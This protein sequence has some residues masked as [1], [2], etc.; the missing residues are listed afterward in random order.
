MIHWR[1]ECPWQWPTYD[2]IF[3]KYGAYHAQCF[4]IPNAWSVLFDA[5]HALRM[6]DGLG[7]S[8]TELG[9][10]KPFLVYSEWT[11]LEQDRK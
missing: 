6:D 4:P 9:L 11:E 10:G 8:L 7:G 1:A 2:V 3:K 5:E